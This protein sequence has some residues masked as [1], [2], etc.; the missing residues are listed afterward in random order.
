MAKTSKINKNELRKKMVAKYAKRRLEL[1]KSIR[2]PHTAPADRVAAQEALAKLP[3]D[4][5]PI[6][7]TNRC[8]ITGRPRGVLS[9]FQMS[10]ITFRE[11]AL[12]GHLTGVVKS[13]W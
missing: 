12:A 13:S 11:K 9:Y 3:R 5:N 8:L 7:V 6:R 1:K 10:R 2:S 4:S